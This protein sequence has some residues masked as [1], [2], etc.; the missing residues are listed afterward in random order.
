MHHE[1]IDTHRLPM[2]VFEAVVF[3]LAA[4]KGVQEWLNG[5]LQRSRLMRIM[6]RDS[7]AY[8]IIIVALD[9]VNFVIW[10]HAR[11]SL[12]SVTFMLTTAIMSTLGTQM[13][14]NIRQEA[15]RTTG[16]SS[17]PSAMSTWGGDALEFRQISDDTG[18]L[19]VESAF[20]IL[21][22]KARAPG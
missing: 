22:A 21:T 20:Y 3:L 19:A 17:E 7:L 18:E 12:V 11:E 9:V 16:Y 5:I 1:L 2:I 4:Y 13:L 10:L 15:S 14:M 6:I 8:F